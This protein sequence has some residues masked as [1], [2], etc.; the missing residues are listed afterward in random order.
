MLQQRAKSIANIHTRRD[1]VRLM[2]KQQSQL[3]TV[4]A[5]TAAAVAHSYR[6]T[7]DLAA[8]TRITGHI[9]RAWLSIYSLLLLLL[10][11][12]CC[13]VLVETLQQTTKT[14]DSIPIPNKS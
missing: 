6:P 11:D 5:A 14:M 7:H 10:S 4:A 8:E 12:Y 1:P 2:S 13:A 3:I 9:A